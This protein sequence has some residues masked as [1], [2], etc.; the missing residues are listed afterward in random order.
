VL[1]ESDYVIVHGNGADTTG[2][3]SFISAIRARPAYQ[4]D[5][6]PIVV[7]EDST[8]ISNFDAAVAAG[9][10]WGYHDKDNNN[11]LTGFQTPPINWGLTTT[12]KRAFFDR[13]A[14]YAGTTVQRRLLLSPTDVSIAVTQGD[15]V[16]NRSASLQSSDG[17][18]PAYTITD[19][20]AW[21]GVSPTGGSAPAQ[22]TLTASSAGLAP[23][24]Y[25]A[26]VT[27]AASGY[28]SATLRVTLTVSAPQTSTYALM[29]S[30]SNTRGDAFPLAGQTVSGPIY[31]FTAPDADVDEVRFYIDDPARTRT[32]Y[33]VEGNAPFDLAGGSTTTANPYDTRNL[34]D[35]QHTITAALRRLSGAIEVVTTE[36]QVGN[37]ARRLTFAPPAL[38]LTAPAPGATVTASASL[39]TSD[40]GSPSFTVSDN[41]GWL[42]V[43]PASGTAPAT[44]SLTAAS[45]GLPA[46]THTATV[47]ATAT[48][49]TAAALS[50]TFTVP[51]TSGARLLMSTSANR[52][53]P[54][55]LDGRT[56]SGPVY[57]FTG[58]DD[59]IER[60]RFHVDD[61]SLA[62]T[63]YQVEENAPFDLAGGTATLAK[64]FSTTSLSNGDHTVTAVLERAGGGA[65]TV[66][67]VMRVAN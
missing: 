54:V 38:S 3:A 32:P 19:D 59:G 30:Q 35:G 56:V 46:G 7:T 25:V 42:T 52:S 41:A 22:L 27:A 63:P 45:A 26:N 12:A 40:G 2:L 18:T 50:V 28:V 55:T 66:N 37:V 21:L 61:P 9:T 47:T 15:P 17:S 67:G 62:G 13:V 34:A 57:I 53:S 20:A 36:F 29:V 8:R 1:S 33:R 48:G 58:P 49:Y 5:P 64:P 51:G 44:V 60:V 39:Q 24:T 65:E 43:S 6:K 4:A 11:Y 16:A 14:Y 31:A 10:S 23:G